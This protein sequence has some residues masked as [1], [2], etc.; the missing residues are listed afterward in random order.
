MN[1][2]RVTTILIL[3]LGLISISCG[4]SDGGGDVTTEFGAVFVSS[5]TT[6]VVGIFDF[7]SSSVSSVQFGLSSTDSDGIIYSAA[8]DELYIASR[9]NNRVEVY[10][11]LKN[12]EASLNINLAFS[13]SQDF[14]NARKLAASGSKVVV[15]QDA[16][17]ANNQ[18]NAYYVYEIGDN[19]AT[20]TNTY[21]ADINLW[22][23][24]FSGNTLYAIQDNSDTLAVYNNFLSNSDGLV[25]PDTK[26]QIEGIVRTHAL[27]YNAS[28]DIMFLSDIGDAGSS[29][30]GAIHVI[31][32]FSSKFTAAGNNGTISS[33]D[34][35][36]IEGSNTQ[37]GNP[38]GIAYDSSSQKIYVAERAVD[39]GKLLEFN[40]PSANGNPSPTFSQNFAGAAAV[41]LAN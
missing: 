3:F 30:D 23:I 20:L 27:H 33:S 15:S 2:I 32:N 1:M 41:Y 22:D 5:N 16:S 39:G 24:Q 8:S 18:T 28:S 36:V 19:S 6:P 4:T 13:S 12:T 37:L 17:D 21:T 35:V 9:T 10:S 40:L 31:T 29:T 14:S 34:Q 38:V 25:S 26:V 7:S 11:D